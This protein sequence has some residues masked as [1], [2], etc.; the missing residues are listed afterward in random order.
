M[1]PSLKKGRLVPSFFIMGN[2][3]DG[4]CGQGLV[5][6]HVWSRLTK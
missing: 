6:H 1:T 2:Y 5:V 3:T 4:V